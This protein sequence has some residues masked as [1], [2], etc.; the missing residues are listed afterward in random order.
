MGIMSLFTTANL[1]LGISLISASVIP[2][3]YGTDADIEF[4]TDAVYATGGC[5]YA[6]PTNGTGYVIVTESQRHT[7]FTN[8]AAQN[9]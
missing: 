1:L 2:R 6:Q 5:P 7:Q 3:Q 4:C 8:N 9:M